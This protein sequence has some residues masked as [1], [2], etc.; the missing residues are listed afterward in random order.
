MKLLPNRIL[1]ILFL[2]E[3]YENTQLIKF[4]VIETITNLI[5]VCWDFV[6]FKTVLM[7]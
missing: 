2:L 7:A 5:L 1:P 4:S 6:I 3:A